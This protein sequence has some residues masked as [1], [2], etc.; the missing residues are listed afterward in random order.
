MALKSR[1]NGKY[2]MLTNK[3]SNY[4]S[5]TSRLSPWIFSISWKGRTFRCVWGWP[6]IVWASERKLVLFYRE[7]T[8]TFRGEKFTS[9]SLMITTGELLLEVVSNLQICKHFYNMVYKSVAENVREMIFSAAY[10]YIQSVNEDVKLKRWGIVEILDYKGS[11][12]WWSPSTISATSTE[13]FY[14]K[15]SW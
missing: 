10:S 8:W 14:L 1:N 4:F 12:D 13:D 3:N 9:M 7:G 15:V 5:I 11:K 6:R 2:D